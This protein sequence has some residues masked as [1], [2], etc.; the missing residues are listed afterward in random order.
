MKKLF[1]K[2]DNFKI[3]F[4]MHYYIFCYRECFDRCYN[5]HV[6]YHQVDCSSILICQRRL[7]ASSSERRLQDCQDARESWGVTQDQHD[8]R[9]PKR[10]CGT[11]IG[12]FYHRTE[13]NPS[14]SDI[15]CWDPNRTVDTVDYQNLHHFTYFL[16]PF[17]VIYS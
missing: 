16:R 1:I 3:L 6:R 15:P 2:R 8:P 12:T 13:R 14:P 4:V 11:H 10:C 17:C 9:Q 5:S 7:V